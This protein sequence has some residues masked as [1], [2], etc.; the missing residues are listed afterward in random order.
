[1]QKLYPVLFA[2]KKFQNIKQITDANK[3]GLLYFPKH[4]DSEEKRQIN[5]IVYI[6]KYQFAVNCK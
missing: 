6:I 3:T 4:Y 2:F 1:M 5:G